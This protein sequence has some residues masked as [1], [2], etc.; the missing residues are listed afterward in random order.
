MDPTTFFTSHATTT[1]TTTITRTYQPVVERRGGRREDGI[2]EDHDDWNAGWQGG[3]I[4]MTGRRD[5]SVA[6]PLLCRRHQC[7][8]LVTVVVVAC[9]SSFLLVAPFYISFRS[10]QIR[11]TDGWTNRPTNER[12][13][14][15]GLVYGDSRTQLKY[16]ER[17]C[18]AHRALSKSSSPPSA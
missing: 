10:D 13:D 15:Q 2:R 7:P 5:S 3:R 11:F 6:F 18:L 4:A 16:T 1:P 14:G 12:A 9:N 8:L 17:N